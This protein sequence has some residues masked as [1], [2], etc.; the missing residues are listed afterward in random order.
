MLILLSALVIVISG[1][2]AGI[3]YIESRVEVRAELH[4][5]LLEER[6]AERTAALEQ[7][8]SHRQKLQAEM[9]KAER[10]ESLGVI[11]GV[12]GL[13]TVIAIVSW[14]LW[15]RV[16]V[17]RTCS[18]SLVPIPNANAPKAPCVDALESA[19]LRPDEID[20]VLSDVGI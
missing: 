15:G 1:V 18:T 13:V 5:G 4:D 6:V 16:W 2:E 17:A 8:A 10:L 7:E 3:E 11:A 14:R 19:G 9:I 20:E 12:G